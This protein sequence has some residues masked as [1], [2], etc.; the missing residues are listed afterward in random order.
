MKKYNVI[1]PM[2]SY[3]DFGTSYKR[4]GF[5]IRTKN[6]R[7]TVVERTDS[8]NNPFFVVESIICCDKKLSEEE[9]KAI[10]D[11]GK[12]VYKNCILVGTEFYTHGTLIRLASAIQRYLKR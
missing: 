1:K 9:V 7:F 6:R 11:S 5:T 10:S 8:H 12:R 3:N 4:D 2:I